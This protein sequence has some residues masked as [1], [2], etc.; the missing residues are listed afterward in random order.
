MGHLV[1]KPVY[2]RPCGGA[3]PSHLL[4]LAP[5]G[6][7]PPVRGSRWLNDS[8]PRSAWSIP[9]RAGEPLITDDNVYPGRVYP[10]PCG[11]AMQ[12]GGMDYQTSGLSPPVR[13]S[14]RSVIGIGQ[15][16]GSIPARAGEPSR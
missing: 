7:S 5:R 6:L 9:A 2:P 16:T 1:F 11:G 14:P 13:G 10:R 3:D 8:K 4:A 12:I 15:L